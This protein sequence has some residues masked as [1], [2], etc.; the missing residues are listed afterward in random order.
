MEKLWA[1]NRPGRNR[2]MRGAPGKRFSMKILGF[3]PCWDDD[4]CTQMNVER[5]DIDRI[6]READFISLHCLLNDET[7]NLINERR[8]GMMKRMPLSSIQPAQA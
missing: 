2:Q 3:D 1:Y 7:A 4:F 8:I 5:A 6:C